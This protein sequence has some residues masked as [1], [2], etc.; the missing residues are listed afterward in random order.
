MQLDELHA[1]LKYCCIVVT[2]HLIITFIYCRVLPAD[3]T[4]S[5]S[6]TL[7]HGYTDEPSAAL[8]MEQHCSVSRDSLLIAT[9]ANYPCAVSYEQAQY[10]V[11]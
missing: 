5:L 2:L 8:S 11:L 1:G 4:S 10:S 3:D 6:M 7:F 9:T